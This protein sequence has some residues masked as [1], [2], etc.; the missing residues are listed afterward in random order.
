[1]F[2]EDIA[3]ISRIAKRTNC[4]IFVLPKNQEISIENALVLMPEGKASISIE[5]VHSLTESLKTRQIDDKFIIIRPAEAMTTEAS[6]ALLKNLEEPQEKVHFVLLTDVP[7]Q[8]LPTILS[9]AETYIWR[10][11]MTKIDQL[12]ADDKIKG[13]AK[14]ILIAKSGD[15]GELAEEICKKKDGTRAYALSVLNVAIEMAYK[16]FMMTK[17]PLFLAKVINLIK[18]YESIS[19]NGHIKLH[20]VADLI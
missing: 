9:R 16:S 13:L 4:S 18:A 6:N 17:K 15:L 1:M 3:D 10:G 5:Q 11:M 7:S 19:N 2:F 8:L 14:R 12:D 20:L